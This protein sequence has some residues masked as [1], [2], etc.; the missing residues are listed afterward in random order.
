MGQEIEDRNPIWTKERADNLF[1]NKDFKAAIVV[2]SRALDIDNEFHKV[3]LNRATC[4]LS[5]GN[6]ELALRDLSQLESLLLTIDKREF[7]EQFYQKILVKTYIKM[8]AIHGIKNDYETALSYFDKIKECK[9]ILDTKIMEKIL[10][11]KNLLEKRLDFDIKKKKADEFL[12]VGELK[13]AEKNYLEIIQDSNDNLINKNEK[14]LSNLSLIY[15]N[16][17]NFDKCILYCDEI[18]KIIKNFKEKINLPKDDNLFHIKILLR[19][20]KCFEKINEISKSQIDI[21]NVERLEI[22]N[23]EINIDIRKIKNDLK[24]KILEKYKE[25]ANCLLEKGQFSDAL[26]LYDKSISLSKFLP[27]IE[28][29]KLL[30]NRASCLVKLGLYTNS[31]EEF[32]RILVS[33]GKLR[34]IAIIKSQIDQ[35]DE[36]KNLEFLT[37]VKRAFVN[38]QLKKIFDAINDY[39]NALDIYPDDKKI[40][41]NLNILKNSV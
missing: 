40:K 30:L 7:E 10:K 24:M 27:K 32:S 11:D 4:Y 22:R 17:G 31:N 15:L 26:E 12:K 41:E 9:I 14:I 34:N 28:G 2:Y 35:I 3:Y 1:K 16:L 39:N 19:R 37:F 8:Y 13:E 18:L 20:A 36:I 23:K 29:I 21:E 6:F 38:T 25:N 5:L 33:L